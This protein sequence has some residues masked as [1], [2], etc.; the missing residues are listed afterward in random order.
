MGSLGRR[1]AREAAGPGEK[2]KKKS[3]DSRIHKRPQLI[4]LGHWQLKQPPTLR[5]RPLPKSAT[6]MLTPPTPREREDIKAPGRTANCPVTPFISAPGRLR[7]CE[8]RPTT[9]PS[10]ATESDPI[11]GSQAG[12]DAVSQLV[13]DVFSLRRAAALHW[14]LSC[15]DAD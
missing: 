3:R 8:V 5:P 12:V 1:R 4:S 14:R 13:P 2:E 6:R 7:L 11:R 10:H 15:D 9:P